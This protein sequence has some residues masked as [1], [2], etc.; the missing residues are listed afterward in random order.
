M[1]KLLPLVVF[2]ALSPFAARNAKAADCQGEVITCFD[3]GT[4]AAVVFQDADTCSSYWDNST[5]QDVV[6]GSCSQ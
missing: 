1:K 2:A 6:Y 3:P 5:K 4:H